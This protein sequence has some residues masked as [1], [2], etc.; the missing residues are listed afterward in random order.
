MKDLAGR[1]VV[2]LAGVWPTD[3]EAA[4]L[5]HFQPAGVILFSRNICNYNALGSLCLFLHEL[6]PDLEI[7]ADHEGGPVSQ[8]AGA[9]GRPPSNWS[10]G[11]LD[12]AG[13]TARVFEETGRRLRAVGI[14]R[15]LAPVA[16]V[17]TE[18]RNP[19]IGSRS[20]GSDSALVS[21]H[22]VAAVTGL[23]SAEMA[24]C[25]KHWPGHGGS[26]GD[27]HLVE[28]GV[29]GGAVPAPFESGLNAGAGAVMVG[30]LLVKERED[31]QPNGGASLHVGFP[32]TLDPEFMSASRTVLGTGHVEDLLFFADDITMGAL[33]PGMKRL[34][35]PVPDVLE[36]GLYDPEMLP[37]A[38][39]EK[40]ADTECD[41]FLI[42]GIP[43]T[44]FPLLGTPDSGLVGAR[45][46]P[47]RS[48]FSEP[49][50]SSSAY[51]E[52]RQRMWTE[53]GIDFADPGSDLMWL[54]YS[55]DDRWA[56]AAG[57]KVGSGEAG[58]LESVGACLER[59]FSSVNSVAALNSRGKPW[60][61]LMVSSH[62]PLPDLEDLAVD[63]ASR[64]VCLAMGHPSLKTD[65]EAWLG[66]GW[67]VGALFDIAQDDLPAEGTK[68]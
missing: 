35:V 17:L 40:L 68:I 37:L 57:Q 46:K 3:Y 65:L 45:N 28:T 64:G 12:D 49:S 66:P 44:A 54:D 22:T 11:V 39:F 19:V 1:L 15:V 42:R 4:W 32:A 25:L 26:S 24:V 33:G 60:N 59:M 62:R 7:M 52:A 38:W 9:L 53:A 13:L 18:G 48:M 67:R 30:H 14:D 31:L 8:L 56:V 20:F 10:L 50:F 2:G 58:T 34:G 43:R 27:S 21:R 29:A 55:R 23:L 5:A 36:S 63:R 47:P 51:A 61:R 41:R 16:D 6:V